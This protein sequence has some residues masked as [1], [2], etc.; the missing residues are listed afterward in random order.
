MDIFWKITTLV[1]ITVV[2]CTAVDK[3]ERD[4]ALLVSMITCCIAAM[5]AISLLEPVFEFLRE[6]DGLAQLQEGFLGILLKVS[7]IGLI[8]EIAG[9]ICSDSGNGSLGKTLYLLGSAT[10]LYLSVPI[11]QALLTMIQEILGQI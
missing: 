4:I 8:T 1:L 2:L 7:G 9:M 6:L 3:Q 11:F 10:I 5:S